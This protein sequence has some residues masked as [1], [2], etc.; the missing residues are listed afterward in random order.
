MP[1]RMFTYIFGYAEIVTNDSMGLR[2]AS[3]LWT[4]QQD[5]LI[6][7][8]QMQSHIENYTTTQSNAG[9][10]QAG[11]RAQLT[12]A[13][14]MDQHG[15]LGT[16]VN[17]LSET[18]Q[19]AVTPALC[20][21]KGEV[22]PLVQMFQHPVLCKEE[23]QVTFWTQVTNITNAPIYMQCTAQVNYTLVQGGTY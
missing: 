22:A 10:T 7:S 20:I 9:S 18:L 23:G 8:I 14:A 13:G 3:G 4:V 19:G 6:H 16:L 21:Y 15:T 1:K 11:I 12:T 5:I 2:V 17:W